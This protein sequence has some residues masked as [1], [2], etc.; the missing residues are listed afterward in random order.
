MRVCLL[1]ERDLAGE[2][3]AGLAP[4]LRVVTSR[5]LVEDGLLTHEQDGDRTTTS[6][7]LGNGTELSSAAI[8]RLW[9]RLVAIDTE[10]DGFDETDHQYASAEWNA[11]LISWFAELGDRMIN[12]PAPHALGG[13][14]NTPSQ[15]AMRACG[16]SRR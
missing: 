1:H 6:L 2:W 3:I 9:C 12:D 4:D 15:W 10:L 16:D 5:E 8:E 7:T 11:T 13:R 14:W